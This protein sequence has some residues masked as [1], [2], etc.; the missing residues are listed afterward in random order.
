MNSQSITMSVMMHNAV[1]SLLLVQ[2]VPGQ[3][4]T[5]HDEGRCQLPE[6]NNMQGSGCPAHP[7]FLAAHELCFTASSRR[8][9]SHLSA[10][11]YKYIATTS[12][13]TSATN[14]TSNALTSTQHGF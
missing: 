4:T 9:P 12:F 14:F 5:A 6:T 8:V 2:L 10:S 11:V 7:S 3:D 1:A 13:S